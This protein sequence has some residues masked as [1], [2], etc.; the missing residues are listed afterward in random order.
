[1]DFEGICLLFLNGPNE[2]LEITLD[3]VYG[4]IEHKFKGFHSITPGI[5]LISY[6]FSG[7]GSEHQSG[8]GAFTALI[9]NVKPEAKRN[10]LVFEWQKES[11][12]FKL[13]TFSDDTFDNENLL[14]YPG[15]I[16]Y[17][18]F[19]SANNCSFYTRQWEMFQSHINSQILSRVFQEL[20]IISDIPI[21]LNNTKKIIQL[22]EITPMTESHHSLLKDLKNVNEDHLGYPMIRFTKIPNLKEFSKSNAS[23]LNPKDLTSCAMDRS[24]I[25]YSLNIDFNGLL[26]ELQLS[27]LLLTFAQ[28]F[29]GFQQ[30]LDIVNLLCHSSELIEKNIKGY[31]KF[32]IIVKEHLDLCPDYFFNGLMNENEFF[33]LFKVLFLNFNCKNEF[34]DD[35]RLFCEKKFGWIFKRSTTNFIELN[36]DD[37]DDDEDLPVVVEL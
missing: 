6:R 35:F 33:N 2:M 36:I 7:W 4:M 22:Y 15:L 37:D 12:M 21:P 34:I 17:S 30:W 19:M 20:S 8:E 14:K 26:G 11:E 1:M 23:V 29:E 9:L 13:K 28:N 5:H 3:G 24:P 31:N 27:F 16:N 32:L 10:V 18:I 25:F